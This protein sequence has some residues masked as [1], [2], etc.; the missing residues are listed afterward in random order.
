MALPPC[1]R[2]RRS[3]TAAVLGL[4]L[5]STGSKALPLDP[6]DGAVLADVYRRTDGNP[7]EAAKRLIEELMTA[8]APGSALPVVAAA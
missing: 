1:R 2:R 3:P 4:D 7:V 5:G 6:C 8:G